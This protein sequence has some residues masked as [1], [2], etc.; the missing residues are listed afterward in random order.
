[1]K[2]LFERWQTLAGCLLAATA[3]ALTGCG[4]SGPEDPTNA[5]TPEQ[6]ASELEQAFA[7][8]SPDVKKEA[9]AASQAMRDAEYQKA[10]MSLETVRSKQN[11]TLEQGIAIQGS[12]ISLESRL[13]QAM[14]DGDPNAARAYQM[15]KAFKRN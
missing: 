15:L 7:N 8:A 11:I 9:A 4:K 10:I 14:E 2:T 5:G 3:I 1:M 12:A 6:A 13:I